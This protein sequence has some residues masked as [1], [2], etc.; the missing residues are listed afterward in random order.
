MTSNGTERPLD[1]E[2]TSVEGAPSQEQQE[3]DRPRASNP[4]RW[5]WETNSLIPFH[6]C[7]SYVAFAGCTGS[8]KNALGISSAQKF[9]RYVRERPA[10]L[11]VVLLRSV[12]TLVRCHGERCTKFDVSPRPAV[13]RDHRRPNARQ[14]SPFANLGRSYVRGRSLEDNAGPV[15]SIL[16]SP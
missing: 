16:S 10:P 1:P 3:G 11:G 6:P 2:V 5:W 9:T 14:P 4:R 7:S 15:L 12:P 8:G 13:A